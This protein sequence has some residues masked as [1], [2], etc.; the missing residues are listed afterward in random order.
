MKTPKSYI[1]SCIIGT[2][3]IVAGVL[4]TIF[5]TEPQGVMQAL[6]FAIMGI[7]AG[8]FGGGIAGILSTRMMKKD[9]NMA[10]QVRIYENDERNIMIGNK[11]KA[12]T[13]T[14][15]QFL[16]LALTLFLAVMQVQLLVILV[17]VGAIFLRVFVL[18][19]LI[20]KYHKEM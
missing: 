4:L 6:P 20:T 7:G 15:T 5:Y 17:F 13:D 11:A 10:T 1:I 18:C 8:S 14:F 3:M 19:Y 16:L 12:K 9:P 2:V